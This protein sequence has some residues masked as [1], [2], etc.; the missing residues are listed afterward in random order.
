MKREM[1]FPPSQLFFFFFLK[2]WENRRERRKEREGKY[3]NQNSWMTE[4][5]TALTELNY[6]KLTLGVG[7]GSDFFVR[8][9]KRKI[10]L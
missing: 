8:K 3:Y 9:Q 4:V 6:L 1:I 7:E 5:S 10:E 2:V